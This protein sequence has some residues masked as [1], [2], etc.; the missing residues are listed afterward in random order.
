[1]ASAESP[2]PNIITLAPLGNSSRS[3]ARLNRVTLGYTSI[4]VSDARRASARSQQS[5]GGT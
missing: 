5:S 4:T 1:M 2:L 3:N